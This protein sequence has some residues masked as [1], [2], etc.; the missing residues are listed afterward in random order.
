MRTMTFADAIEDVLMEAMTADPRIIVF[1]EDVHAIRMNLYARFG[2]MRVRPTPISE[3]AFL[4]AGVTAAM[5]GLRPIVEIMMVDFIAVAVDALVNHAAKIEAFSG[6]KWKVP[7]VVR[8]ACGGGYGDGGQHEQALWG[9]LAQVPGMKV[10]VPSNPADA[11][12]LMLSAIEDDGPVVFMEHKLLADYW[13]DYLADGGRMNLDYDI[14]EEGAFGP[15]PDVWQPTPIGE[16]KIVREGGDLTMAAVGVGLHRCLEA[17]AR[18]TEQGIEA[19]VVDLRTVSPLDTDTLCESVSKTR[20]LLVADEDYKSF[21]LSGELA[22]TLMEAGIPARFARVCVEETIPYDRRREGQV[23]P[24]VQRIVEVARQ[25][26]DPG[27]LVA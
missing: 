14:P 5:G 23:L 1:G 16:A 26:V 10:V 6:G 8:V 13:L 12:G 4:G 7:M 19:S 2:E 11:G 25:L 22:A 15:V 21:G 17:A 27:S 24:N 3:S 9:L 18:L 20:G